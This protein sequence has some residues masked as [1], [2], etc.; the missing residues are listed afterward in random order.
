MKISNCTA[1]CAT[2]GKPLPRPTIRV[3]LIGSHRML[4]SGEDT[5]DIPWVSGECVKGL[6]CRIAVPEHEVWM[7]VVNDRAVSD[8]Y[9]PVP[10]DTVEILSPVVGG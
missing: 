2:N 10:G 5:A 9:V 8:C 1:D 4:P 3:R 6:L 7:V